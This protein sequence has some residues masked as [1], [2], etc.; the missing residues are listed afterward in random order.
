MQRN[1][2]HIGILN[3]SYWTVALFLL[4]RFLLFYHSNMAAGHVSEDIIIVIWILSI[5]NVDTI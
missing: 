3:Q 2:R 5:F 4:K 1:G